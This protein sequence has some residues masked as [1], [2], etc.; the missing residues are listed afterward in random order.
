MKNKVI[1]IVQKE[2]WNGK[3]DSSPSIATPFDVVKWCFI[4]SSAFLF[5]YESRLTP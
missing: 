1:K 4:F 3:K 2:K 5:H